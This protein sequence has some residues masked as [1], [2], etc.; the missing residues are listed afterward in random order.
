MTEEPRT[1]ADDVDS[2]LIEQ[3][4]QLRGI[5]PSPAAQKGFHQIVAAELAT[6]GPGVAERGAFKPGVVRRAPPVPW[7]RR[8]IRVPVPV[9]IAAGLSAIAL[10]FVRLPGAAEHSTGESTVSRTSTIS[11]VSPFSPTSTAPPAAA[12]TTPEPTRRTNSTYVL[13]V[14][15][16]AMETH[17]FFSKDEQ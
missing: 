1:P 17:Y 7:W 4:A 15:A 10:L 13:G 16:V 3:L 14:G 6:V 12:E 5:G 11:P 8:S 9:C 2:L